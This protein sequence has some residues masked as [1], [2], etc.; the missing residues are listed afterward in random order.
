[1]VKKLLA[2]KGPDA[3]TIHKVV[4]SHFYIGFLE[5]WVKSVG[6]GCLCVCIYRYKYIYM[7]VSVWSVGGG[8]SRPES[9]R[10]EAEEGGLWKW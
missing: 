2:V 7:C 10:S 3:F 6:G 9:G 5:V 8:V 1:M 4:I